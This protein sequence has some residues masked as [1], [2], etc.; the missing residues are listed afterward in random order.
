MMETTITLSTTRI[1]EEIY[2]LSALGNYTKG[3]K[4]CIALLTPDNRK[5]LVKVVGEAI[6]ATAIRLIGVITD[7]DFG[8]D[9]ADEVD[10]VRLTLKG[11]AADC[12]MAV[13]RAIEG[14]V[15]YR[16]L[17][18]IYMESSPRQTEIYDERFRQSVESARYLATVADDIPDLTACYI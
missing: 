10:L 14:A 12:A 16:T 8:T 7:I 5:A 9:K 17:G 3:D 2:A 13:R 6:A 1:L 4:E 11:R 15:T 18:N